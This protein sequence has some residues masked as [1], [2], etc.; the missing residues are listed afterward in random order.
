MAAYLG[1]AE[2][3]GRI[4]R[5]RRSGRGNDR[6]L[7]EGLL[8]PDSGMARMLA[9]PVCQGSRGGKEIVAQAV[10]HKHIGDSSAFCDSLP[11]GVV[12]LLH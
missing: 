2:T 11:H 6:S 7:M 1:L 5:A 12:S 8:T 4:P 9:V 10:R 3:R